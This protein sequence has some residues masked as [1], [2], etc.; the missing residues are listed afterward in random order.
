MFIGIRVISIAIGYLLGTF[1]TGYLYGKSQGIDV[2]EHG[3]GNSG[4]T[5]TLRT[6]GWKAGVVTFVGDVLK[7]VLSVL[8]VWLLFHNTCG[9]ATRLMQF[10]AGFGAVLGHNF[11]FFLKFKGG[12]GIACTAAVVVSVCPL[13]LP[14]SALIFFPVV[15][16]TRYVSLGSVLFVIGFL[17]QIIVFNHLGYMHLDPDYIL[18]FNIV[19]ACFTAMAV[20]RHRQNIVRLVKGTENKFGQKEK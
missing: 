5:N 4:T 6:L 12:K 7:T 20:F 8:I 1:Q 2:R 15:L 10:Y 14:I 9:D 17:I 3:S 19:A 18:E 11:P 13:T 16:I